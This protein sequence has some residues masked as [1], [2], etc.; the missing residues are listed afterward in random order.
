[1][2]E[3]IM[4]GSDEGCGK[5]MQPGPGLFDC[6]WSFMLELSVLSLTG[7]LLSGMIFA[8]ILSF[9]MKQ[10]SDFSTDI[11]VL[12]KSLIQKEKKT[13]CYTRSESRGLRSEK[14]GARLESH[15]TLYAE[16]VAE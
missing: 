10:C 7:V 13:S 4:R 6:P 14:L 11:K 5:T 8:F 9:K 16:S 15:Y 3:D 2:N 12:S 1:M